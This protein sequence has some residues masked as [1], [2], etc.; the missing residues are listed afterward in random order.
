MLVLKGHENPK[1]QVYPVL[2]KKVFLK[3]ILQ[4]FFAN[5]LFLRRKHHIFYGRLTSGQQYQIT[6]DLMSAISLLRNLI[7]T[8]AVLIVRRFQQKEVNFTT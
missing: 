2:H 8:V 3:T 4:L 1:I 5:S 7:I 6:C